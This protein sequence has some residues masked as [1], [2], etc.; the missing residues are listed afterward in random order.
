M[1]MTKQNCIDTLRAIEARLE[2]ILANN[3][4][5][6]SSQ[7]C[8]T[9]GNTHYDNWEH[10]QAADA[11]QGALTRVEKARRILNNGTTSAHGDQR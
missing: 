5:D 6:V 8:G 4:L 2:G 9:C 11:I 10:K 7:G 3:V 1:A